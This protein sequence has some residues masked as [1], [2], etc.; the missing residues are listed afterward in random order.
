MKDREEW[1]GRQKR[2]G[3]QGGTR[4]KEINFQKGLQERNKDYFACDL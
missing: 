4:G 2:M 3:K 1:Y